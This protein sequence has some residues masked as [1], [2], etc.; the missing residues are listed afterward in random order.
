[1]GS[2]LRPRSFKVCVENKCSSV[3]FSVPQGSCGCRV[4]YR[5][6]ASTVKDVVDSSIQIR[7]YADDQAMKKSFQ[8]STSEEYQTISALQNCASKVK[9]WMDINRLKISSSKTELIIIGSRK[10]L[11]KCNTETI[12]ITGDIIPCKPIFKYLRALVDER[13][14]HLRI[15]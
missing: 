1:M 11:L 7:G 8:A 3:K 5:V 13:K 4:S 14:C 10:Q 12:N 6:Y 9:G 2:Y 15:I